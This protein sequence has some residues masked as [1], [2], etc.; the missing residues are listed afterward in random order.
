ME[1]KAEKTI[2]RPNALIKNFIVNAEAIKLTQ[3]LIHNS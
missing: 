3:K 2:Y 1:K